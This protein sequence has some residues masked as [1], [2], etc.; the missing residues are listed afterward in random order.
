[1]YYNTQRIQFTPNDMFRMTNTI[2]LKQKSDCK[3]NLKNKF[4]IIISGISRVPV[5]TVYARLNMYC[6]IILLLLYNK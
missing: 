3:T 1:M 2:Y 4:K 5:R 6:T